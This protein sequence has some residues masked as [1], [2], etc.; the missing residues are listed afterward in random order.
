[1][2]GDRKQRVA[3]VLSCWSGVESAATSTRREG[4]RMRGIPSYP[5]PN[6]AD[7]LSVAKVRVRNAKC[8]SS[9]VVLA[10]KEGA[11]SICHERHRSG[12]SRWLE[13]H[14]RENKNHYFKVGTL[15]QAT[16][17]HFIFD[18]E[19]KRLSLTLAI[20]G[21]IPEFEQEV[22]LKRNYKVLVLRIISRDNLQPL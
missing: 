7:S 18:I 4:N 9:P 11:W 5:A 19:S 2:E 22:N 14:R 3:L 15:N 12:T 8:F 1:M 17:L 10:V 16:N 21:E 6:W 13:L 20:S